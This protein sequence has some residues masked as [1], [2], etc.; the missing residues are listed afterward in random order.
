MALTLPELT[1]HY[2]V[3]EL[4]GTGTTSRV[5]LVT[6]NC[7]GEEFACKIP[8]DDE[9]LIE[10]VYHEAETM[11]K[12]SKY[13]NE[14]PFLTFYGLYEYM[15]RPVLVS[16]YFSGA[17][18][19]GELKIKSIDQMAP[20]FR[21]LLIQLEWLHNRGFNHGDI[22]MHNVMY[23]GN[24]FV[25]IDVSNN[26]VETDFVTGGDFNTTKQYLNIALEKGM[27]GKELLIKADIFEFGAYIVHALITGEVVLFE[28][29]IEDPKA[30]MIDSYFGW[31]ANLGNA[32]MTLDISKRPSAT[33]LLKMIPEFGRKKR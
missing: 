13:P 26:A 15:S 7:S 25:F 1:R 11:S 10:T 22:G 2:T 6:D 3:G 12:I 32:A 21:Q 23:S 24:R 18:D 4:I 14:S 30:H 19:L 33:E 9:D 16:E 5:Y 31:A 28:E 17:K 8:E 20:I 29:L 27:K